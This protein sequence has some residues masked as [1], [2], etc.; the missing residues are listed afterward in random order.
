MYP[1]K[2]LAHYGVLGMKWGRRNNRDLNYE[3]TQTGR[4]YINDIL[5]R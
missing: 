4:D 3:D 2:Y 5:G 1:D